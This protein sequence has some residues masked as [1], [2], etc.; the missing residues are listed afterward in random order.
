MFILKVYFSPSSCCCCPVNQIEL[1]VY[2]GRPE[3]VEYCKSEGI[4]VEGY[5]TDCRGARLDESSIFAMAER[6]A[7]HLGVAFGG[8]VI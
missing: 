6:W 1:S 5:Y 8:G 4:L 3:V 2:K 7:W